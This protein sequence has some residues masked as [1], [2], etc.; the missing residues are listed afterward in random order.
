MSISYEQ[1]EKWRRRGDDKKSS[2]TYE[3]FIK[4]ERAI[5]NIYIKSSVFNFVNI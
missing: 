3:F 4:I 1:L 5:I 2:K